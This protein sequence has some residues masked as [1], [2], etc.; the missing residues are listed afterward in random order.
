MTIV[1][2]DLYRHQLSDRGDEIAFQ[3]PGGTTTFGEF[4]Q[5][6]LET[7][8][9]LRAQGVKPSDV[10]AVWMVNRVDWLALL[11]AISRVGGTLAAVNTRYKSGDVQHVLRQSGATMLIMEASF[12]KIDF[13]SI[14]ADVDFEQTPSLKHISIFSDNTS[15]PNFPEITVSRFE[16]TS[17]QA[18]LGEADAHDAQTPSILFVTSGTTK[19]PKL[20]AHCAHTFHYNAGKVIASQKYDHDTRLLAALP[21]C[22]VFCLMGVFTNLMAGGQTVLMETFEGQE[23]ARLLLKH[24]I[25][26]LYGSEELYIRIAENIPEGSD[27]SFAH[28]YGIASFNASLRVVGPKLLKLGFPLGSLYGSSEILGYVAS[29][30]DD[31]D[32]EVRLTPGGYPIAGAEFEMRVRDLETGE[33]LPPN[34]SGAL[35]VRTPA[36]FVGYYNNPEATQEAITEDGYF[37]TGDMAQITPDGALIYEGRMGDAYRLAGYLVNAEEVEDVMNAIEGVREA[38]FV[39]VRHQGENHAAAFVM[40]EPDSDLTGASIQAILRAGLASYKVPRNVWI[41][42]EF[43]MAHGTNGSKVRK[44][45]LRSDAINRLSTGL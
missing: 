21:L 28:F 30:Y 36:N 15:L 4:H 19:A 26:H 3:A 20:V 24:R 31:P 32:V 35:E 25:T 1:L 39:V 29:F 42:Q 34:H 6:V 13:L 33:L 23:A 45:V 40:L 27:L 8:G 9:W 7:A 2:A 22:G 38:H 41:V 14:L 5:R 10:V 11:F 17:A 12:L 37:K 16:P 18:A 44:E 43:P